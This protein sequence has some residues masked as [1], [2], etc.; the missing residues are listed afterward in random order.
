MRRDPQCGCMGDDKLAH[1][2]F[3]FHRTFQPEVQGS[4]GRTGSNSS[5]FICGS[6]LVHAG[7]LDNIGDV[8]PRTARSWIFS[9]PNCRY[10]SQMRCLNGGRETIVVQL[11]LGCS[12]GTQ[13]DLAAGSELASV[14][15]L[16]VATETEARGRA[17]DGLPAVDD[18]PPTR[19]K[20]GHLHSSVGGSLMQETRWAAPRQPVIRTSPATHRGLVTHV[21]HGCTFSWR[22]RSE[23]RVRALRLS[24]RCLKNWSNLRAETKTPQFRWPDWSWVRRRRCS[25]S[26]ALNRH[27]EAYHKGAI[28]RPG[29]LEVDLSHC[30]LLQRT[31]RQFVALQINAQFR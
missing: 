28:S 3:L 8:L 14:Y 12:E 6:D 30:T 29:F 9:L 7:E 19:K 17:P 23:R 27:G 18:P 15:I 11:R 13:N 21:S 24:V 5:K 4:A 10:Q 31:I 16:T 20:P 1:A 22:E 2:L 25:P 26:A